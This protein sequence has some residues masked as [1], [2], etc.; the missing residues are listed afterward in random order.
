[1]AMALARTPPTTVADLPARRLARLGS[2]LRLLRGGVI[3]HPI[4]AYEAWGTLNEA[5]DNAI[6]IFTGLSPSAHAASSPDDARPGWWETMIGPGRPLDTRRFFVV[7]INS[8]GSPFGSSS[9]ASLDPAT[10]RPYGISFP[11]IAVEDIA[12]AGREALRSLGIERVAALVGPSLGGMVVLAYCALFPGEVEHLLTISGAARATPF[13]IALRSL[14]REMVRSDPA[15][16]GGNYEPGRGP[17]L[18]LRLARKL[19]TITYRSPQ[20]WDQ[21]FGRMRMTDTVGLS[22]DFRPQFEVEGYLEHQAK[23]FSESFDANCY[24]YLSRAMD[25][26]DLAD[27]GGGSLAAAFARFGVRRSLVIGVESD[28]LFPLHQQQEVA[29][30]LRAAG[31]IVEYHA[32]PSL[33]G[34]D[35]FLSDLARFEPAIGG[36]I[37]GIP[38]RPAIAG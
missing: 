21:R 29:D 17:R 7:C 20:E 24:L 6:V 33:Q 22:G 9:P 30:H 12:S 2:P 15:W 25:Q 10:G 19:G 18:G 8:L 26:F 11:E 37:A 31:G 23:R 14:Q 38:G 4:V 13:A 16:R 28:M 32:F 1:M 34:H 3:E 35:A 5:R 27:H 36:F